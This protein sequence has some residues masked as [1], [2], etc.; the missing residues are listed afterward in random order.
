MLYAYSEKGVACVQKRNDKSL[1]VKMSRQNCVHK[2]K[3]SRQYCVHKDKA[4][5]YHP[6]SSPWKIK[7]KKLT[8]NIDCALDKTQKKRIEMWGLQIEIQKIP[9]SDIMFQSHVHLRGGKN[10]MWKRE[11]AGADWKFLSDRQ[12]QRLLV[13]TMQRQGADEVTM[14]QNFHQKV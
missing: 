12:L 6:P 9:V 5:A 11:R 13:A 1:L 14:T 2:D 8:D 3:M 7:G 4:A 10:S